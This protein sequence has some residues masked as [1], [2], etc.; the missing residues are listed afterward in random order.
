MQVKLVELRSIYFQKKQTLS[1]KVNTHLDK[2][3]SV[4][5]IYYDTLDDLRNKLLGE[6]YDYL[7]KMSGIENR[8]KKLVSNMK[9]YSVMEFYHE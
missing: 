8:L 1:V 7:D 9:N 6:E 3:E 5:K 4:F 2:I